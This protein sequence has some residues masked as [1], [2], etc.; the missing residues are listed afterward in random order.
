ML[1]RILIPLIFLSHAL[2]SEGQCPDKDSLWKRLVYLRDSS[3][4]PIK[5][6]QSELLA[7]MEQMSN[8][9][10][11]D[12]T[13]GFLLRRI[14][15]T[16]YAQADY[17]KAID[18]F[19]HSVDVVLANTNKGS[20]NPEDLIV[21]YYY[22]GIFYDALN[23][24]QEKMKA[25][26]KCIDE[27]VQLSLSRRLIPNSQISYIFALYERIQYFFNTGD[28]YSCLED[29]LM[30]EKLSLEF[31]RN[32]ST[33][34][35]H[36]LLNGYAS[37]S[38][39]WS[40]QA[41]LELKKFP[42][43]EKLLTN[44]LDE[45]KKSGRPEY[46]A[47]IYGQLANVEMHNG[48][49]ERALSY[50]QQELKY[51]KVT[52]NYF[53][54]KQTLK[55]IGEN[56]YFDHYKNP[57]MAIQYYR[58]AISVTDKFNI[59]SKIDSAESLRIFTNFANAYV[60]KGYYDSAF[61]YY[62]KAFDQIKPGINEQ[63]I[64]S[65]SAE[66]MMEI[67]KVH[68]LTSL[69]IDKGDA[70]WKKYLTTNKLEDIKRAAKIYK[71]ADRLLD[72]IKTQQS[73]LKSKLFWRS[74]SRR[75]Y[76]HAIE[77]SYLENNPEDAFYFFEKSRAVLL[78]DQ[79]NAQGKISAN[80]NLK[81]AQ[82]KRRILSLEND[83]SN[84]SPASQQYIQL[85]NEIFAKNRELDD[86][87]QS[88]KRNNPLF[89]QSIFDTSFITIA[90]VRSKLLKDHQALLEIFDGD[91]SA[92]T[93]L[94]IASKTYLNRLV[95]KDLDS[96]I[97]KCIALIQDQS[98]LNKN[99][100]SFIKTSNH[101]Y[102]LIFNHVELPSGR[103]IISPDGPYFPFEAMVTTISNEPAFLLDNHA[104]SYTYSARYL[105][106]EF[107]NDETSVPENFLGIAPVQY[108][109]SFSMVNLIGSDASLNRI[110]SNFNNSRILVSNQASRKNFLQAY[111]KYKI[112]QLYTHATANTKLGDP[113]INFA[114]SA[115][116]LSELI[117]QDKPRTKLVILSACETGIG[118]IY[119]GEGVFSFNRGFALL[120]IP[121]SV[122][123]LWS[124]DNLA[125]YE[126]TESFNEY[127][128]EGMPIDVALQKAKLD[129]ISKESKINRLPYYWAAMV[130]VG[131]SDP[132]I[133]EKKESWGGIVIWTGIAGFVLFMLWTMTGKMRRSSKET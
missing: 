106:N 10:K 52:R 68:Y 82:L 44:K 14:G 42:D 129:Y 109:P 117:P 85:Q 78:N 105:M 77:V 81:L 87:S 35:Y 20:V 58:D 24:E 72:K 132:V 62:Q 98:I 39:G 13:Y 3:H 119:Q 121:S 130:V 6:V 84:T 41:L 57:E 88:I 128:S 1:K 102:Q 79:I 111:S 9:G 92:Y 67:K 45:Y 50:F 90:D 46:V 61:S 86:L 100:S 110:G 54:Y 83:R 127:I 55:T 21:S 70:Y 36:E 23:N 63:G 33:T 107:S 25:I 26:N 32:P 66:E 56:I 69:V 89:Y 19:N 12:S 103:I 126:L 116:Y 43:A 37:S 51:E 114:D 123:N 112:I 125:T 104:I 73:D 133:I 2:P 101:L 71:T 131:K 65:R 60:Y 96:T 29:A 7:C 5:E 124:V 47:M 27:S 40:V 16:Y 38:L 97:G 93:L 99:Y 91:S 122:I 28:Y 95:K 49:F 120:G 75:L 4:T 115:L 64:L 59:R 94:V 18:Y 53:N 31:V 118:E 48:N 113:Y 17:L 108:A 30:C 11:D 74:D 76:E 22:L 34:K 15:M 80:D 8:C